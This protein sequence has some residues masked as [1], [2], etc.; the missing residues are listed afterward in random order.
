MAVSAITPSVTSAP[1]EH[2]RSTGN[3]LLYRIVNGH[4]CANYGMKGAVD[5]LP[6]ALGMKYFSCAMHER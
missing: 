3:H 4:N 1:R 2:A 5:Q 6:G